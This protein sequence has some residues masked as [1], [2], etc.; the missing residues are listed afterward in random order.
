MEQWLSWS[1]GHLV[2]YEA[3]IDFLPFYISCCLEAV[4]YIHVMFKLKVCISK[5]AIQ[6]RFIDFANVSFL[7]FILYGS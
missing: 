4:L 3:A 6:I 5:N 2:V 1:R 7:D